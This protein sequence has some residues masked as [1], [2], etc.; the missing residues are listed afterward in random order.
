LDGVGAMCRVVG[1]TVVA[2]W[3]AVMG[4][5]AAWG[6]LFDSLAGLED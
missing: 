4:L 1:D 3:E 5:Y 2:A 6:M